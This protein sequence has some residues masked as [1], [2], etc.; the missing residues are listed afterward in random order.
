MKFLVAILIAMMFAMPAAAQDN[1][2]GTEGDSLVAGDPW[3]VGLTFTDARQEET[4]GGFDLDVI[5]YLSGYSRV[6]NDNSQW[7]GWIM[8]GNGHPPHRL[9]ML[10]FQWICRQVYPGSNAIR[11]SDAA[12]GILCSVSMGIAVASLIQS[13]SPDCGGAFVGG[14]LQLDGGCAIQPAGNS[15]LIISDLLNVRTGPADWYPIKGKAQHDHYYSVIGEDPI[16]GW[17]QIGYNGETGWVNDEAQYVQYFGVAVILA[18]QPTPSGYDADCSNAKQTTEFAI[19]N[20]VKVTPGIS[21][22]LRADA[23]TG[24]QQI[25]TLVAGEELEIISGSVCNNGYRWWQIIADVN[26][27]GQMEIG[28]TAEGDID[29]YWLELIQN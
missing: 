24:Y 26:N 25:G 29:G 3:V 14:E 17:Y 28:W 12:N 27:D 8:D 7:N 22:R 9:S 23:G 16:S 4:V 15:V 11:I 1:W 13:S 19:G 5:A 2:A 10:N 6:Y 21:N 18:P 20:I